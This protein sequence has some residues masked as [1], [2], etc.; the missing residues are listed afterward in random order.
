MHAGYLAQYYGRPMMDSRGYGWGEGMMFIWCVVGLAVIAGV[1]Y[2]MRSN[3]HIN[4]HAQKPLDLA[5]K[6]Y[7][8]GDI[9]KVEF[10]QIKKDIA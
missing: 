4:P 6:R 10:E 1:I 7:A 2:L 3:N 9:T 8:A 5:K